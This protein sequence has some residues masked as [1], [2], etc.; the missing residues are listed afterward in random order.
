LPV[1]GV[2]RQAYERLCFHFPEG[3]DLDLEFWEDFSLAFNP[4]AKK[5]KGRS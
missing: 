5:S 1:E 3:H 2:C 4:L